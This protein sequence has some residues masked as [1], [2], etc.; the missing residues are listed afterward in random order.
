MKTLKVLTV[1][2][3]ISVFSLSLVGHFQSE[4]QLQ[5]NNKK[6]NSIYCYNEL[7]FITGNGNTCIFGAGAC[8]PNPC[9]DNNNN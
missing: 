5:D 7:G 8:V 6:V 3:S 4:A 9:P 1:F 2:A